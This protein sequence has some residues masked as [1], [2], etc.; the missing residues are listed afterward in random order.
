MNVIIYIWFAKKKVFKNGLAKKYVGSETR[1]DSWTDVLNVWTP[2]GLWTYS[3]AWFYSSDGQISFFHYLVILI[4][5]NHHNHVVIIVP[6]MLG[7]KT[8][9][10]MS[11]RK[12]NK[13]LVNF[14]SVAMFI[15]YNYHRYW[16]SVYGLLIAFL[17]VSY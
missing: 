12:K 9:P 8:R 13:F 3:V 16:V 11:W 15:V 10:W 1:I 14:F 17:S 2:N 6:G 4:Q 5:Y 7:M